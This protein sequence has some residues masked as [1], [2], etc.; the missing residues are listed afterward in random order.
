M[1]CLIVTR[2]GALRLSPRRSA[3]G[4]GVLAFQARVRRNDVGIEPA[5]VCNSRGTRSGA[6]RYKAEG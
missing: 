3:P 1:V 4:Y 5:A 2:G 6:P